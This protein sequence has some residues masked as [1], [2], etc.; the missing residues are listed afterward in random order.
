MQCP[1]CDARGYLIVQ[2]PA[3]GAEMIT[4]SCPFCDGIGFI[5]DDRLISNEKVKS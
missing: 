2:S 3:D 5:R 1:D 4:A